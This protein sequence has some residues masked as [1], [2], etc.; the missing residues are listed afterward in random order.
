MEFEKLS[1][2]STMFPLKNPQSS[3][4]ARVA[5]P[6]ICEIHN[7]A[8]SIFFWIPSLIF[9]SILMQLSQLFTKYTIGKEVVVPFRV[10]VVM[11]CEFGSFLAC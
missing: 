2:I 4:Y 6:Q 10:W 3:S 8:K 11:T 7:L 9:F 1:S 5:S